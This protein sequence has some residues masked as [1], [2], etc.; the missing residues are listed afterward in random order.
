MKSDG[1]HVDV[2]EIC[3]GVPSCLAPGCSSIGGTATGAGKR[4]SRASPS[5][6]DDDM[7][8]AWRVVEKGRTARN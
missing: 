4:P 2:G 8:A 6:E 1:G 7:S 3:A 5:P